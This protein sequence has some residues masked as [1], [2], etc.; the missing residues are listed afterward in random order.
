MPPTSSSSTPHPK[1]GVGA[2]D[3]ED[4]VLDHPRK[5]AAWTPDAPA[6]TFRGETLTYGSLHRRV[7]ALARALADRGL[8]RG[9]RVAILAR[10][11]GFFFQVLYACLRSGLVL[12]PLNWRLA[13]REVDDILDLA[14]PALLVHDGASDVSGLVWSGPRVSLEEL[15]PLA[16]QHGGSEGAWEGT[17]LEDPALLLFTSGTTGRPKAAVLPG[18][19]LF[20]N[21]VNTQIAWALT[22]A[23]S[24]I[25][26]TP[27]FHTGAINVLALPLL[28]CGGHVV[29]HESFDAEAILSDVE[30]CRI[31]VLF[32]VP[33]TLQML[34]EHPTCPARDLA[35]LRL[36][37]CGGAPLPIALIQAWQARGLAVT[38][39]FGMTEVG[40]NCFF[41]PPSETLKRAG[42]VGK[43]IFSCS[44]RLVD[45]D[46]RD[47]PQGVVGELWLRGP[48][49][50]EG[51]FR[52]PK[53]TAEALTPEGWFRTGDLARTDADGFF[54]I[55]GRKKDMYISGGENVYPAEVEV[56]L[57]A[58]P[59]VAECA[60][61]SMPDSRW[62][63]VGCAFYVPRADAPDGEGLRRFLRERLAGYKVPKA[64]VPV[65]A[66]PRNPSGKV[67]KEGLIREARTHAR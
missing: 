59:D 67:V 52:N 63:E 15:E 1:A 35:S 47:V 6:L 37:L 53:A 38:Q 49:V 65:A 45:N 26:Y 31:T 61:V 27:L 10:N 36:L 42:T 24:T 22:R 17:G 12:A 43:P 8:V 30:K 21:S 23:D 7:D 55:A 58:H 60:V 48:H 41:L 64:F 57:A 14:A 51:Y 13:P 44:A 2:W 29:L 16:T 5:W 39:G 9:D 54:T 25:V 19:Q 62:G 11:H 46:G 50:C 3:R 18:R 66:L 4:P 32:G 20:W 34:L 33:T 56:A 40:P 28:Q